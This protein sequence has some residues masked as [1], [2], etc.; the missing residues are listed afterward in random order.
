[1]SSAESV[2]AGMHA[3]IGGL[4]GVASMAMVAARQEAILR[5][6]AQAHLA[7]VAAQA[8]TGVLRSTVA[9]LR[10]DLEDA[11]EDLAM[12]S[13]ANASLTR[14]LAAV[15]RERDALRVRRSA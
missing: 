10:E 13:E 1:M 8:R 12:A 14:Q 5:Q 2:N 4:V 15:T 11:R 6:D 7:A 9:E 3:S